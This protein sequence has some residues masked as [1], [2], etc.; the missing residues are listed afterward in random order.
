M[1]LCPRCGHWHAEPSPERTCW[2]CGT[3][4][5]TVEPANRT[6][7]ARPHAR[8]PSSDASDALPDALPNWCEG[9]RYVADHDE[10]MTILALGGETPIA[11]G[12]SPE[13]IEALIA[14]LTKCLMASRRS[15]SVIDVR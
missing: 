11:L 9:V 7:R 12:A 5:G 14:A 15:R 3:D 1:I 4:L 10:I 13:E 2:V 6:P 8:A